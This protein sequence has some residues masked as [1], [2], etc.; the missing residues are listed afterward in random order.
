MLY[1]VTS[2]LAVT[3]QKPRQSEIL[4]RATQESMGIIW[5]GN[6]SNSHDL[7]TVPEGGFP[8]DYTWC[9]KDNVN[10]CTPSLNQHIPQVSAHPIPHE[11]TY[12]AYPPP[13]L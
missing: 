1:F 3:A 5:R 12:S 2:I 13:W 4:P 8:T 9:D 10:Y 6:S 7:L 11:R